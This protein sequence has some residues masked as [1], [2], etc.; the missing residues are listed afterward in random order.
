ML[1]WHGMFPNKF[2]LKKKVDREEQRKGCSE[3]LKKRE[4]VSKNDRRR[5]PWWSSG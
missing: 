5:I 3:E 1:L 4:R 2:R